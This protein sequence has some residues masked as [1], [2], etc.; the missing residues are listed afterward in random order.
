MGITNIKFGRNPAAEAGYQ[1]LRAQVD[2]S[3]PLNP[4]VSIEV[5]LATA[6]AAGILKTPT[7]AITNAGAAHNFFT[8]F[9]S[10]TG[11]FSKAQP[12]EAD[13]T[14]T[15]ITTGNVSI[16]M[17][18]FVPKAPNDA[19][20]FLDGTGNYGTP[21]GGGGGGGGSSAVAAHTSKRYACVSTDRSS[22]IYQLG[23]VGNVLASMWNG[24]VAPTTTHPVANEIYQTSNDNVA[25][26]YGKMNY[27]TGKNL[28]MLFN[29][30]ITQ[31]TD[32]RFWCGFSDTAGTT[33]WGG[34]DTP[35][36]K[37]AAFRFSSV[38]T[39]TNY[40]CCTSDGSTQTTTDSGVAADTNG[41]AFAIE[42]ADGTPA[43]LFYI[44]SVLVATVT[45][46]LPGNGVVMNYYIG[47]GPHAYGGGVLL[48]FSEVQTWFDK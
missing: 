5:P 24:G 17:H 31:I 21:A 33:A 34:T 23:D 38:A 40:Q 27:I 32:T 18:G 37:F 25:G 44:D 19:T 35:T 42:F 20:R 43:V 14:F 6:T 39:D 47:A 26:Y 16:T 30:Y 13:L 8:S 41:H 2:V 48:G 45:T 1:N 28:Q 11:L 15:D 4:L 10:T 7:L 12:A 3:D 36:G 29:G 46:N 9:D 22:T